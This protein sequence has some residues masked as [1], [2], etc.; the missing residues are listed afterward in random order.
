MTITFKQFNDFVELPDEQISEEQLNEIWPFT[1]EKKKQELA[2]QRIKLLQQKKDANKALNAEKDKQ[3]AAQKQKN[4]QRDAAGPKTA[5]QQDPNT[6]ANRRAAERDWVANMQTEGVFQC[7]LTLNVPEEEFKK[8]K[9]EMK[10][11]GLP[12]LEWVDTT[13]FFSDNRSAILAVE[14]YLKKNK[15]PYDKEIE[16]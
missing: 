5:R 7:S 8:I 1:D 4:A 15:I 11:A 3:L 12:T 9:Q 10:S 14:K 16:K 6:A 13:R 2:Q